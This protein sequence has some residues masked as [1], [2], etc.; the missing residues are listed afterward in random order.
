[1]FSIKVYLF[2]VL[3]TTIILATCTTDQDCGYL[4]DCI[5]NQCQ[6]DNGW[7]GINCSTL[8]FLP[9]LPN[10]GLRQNKSQNWCGTILPSEVDNYTFTMYSSDMNN[11]SL[12]VWLSGS[13]I[14]EAQS[15]TGPNGPYIPTGNIA[16]SAEAHNPSALRAPDGTYILFDSYGGPDSNCPLEA[17]L[18]TCKSGS[19]CKPKMPSNGGLG[20][21]VFHISNSVN[22]PWTPFNTTIDFPCF[23][24]NL[25]PAPVFLT[26]GSLVIIFHC[27]ND[28]THKQGD[29]VMVRSDDWRNQPF[30]RVNNVVWNVCGNGANGATCVQPHPE[31][32]FFFTRTSPTKGTVSYHI[33]LHNTPRGIH[34]FSAD[35][36]TFTLQQDV[37]NGGN[38]LAPFVYENII[39]QTDGTNLTA[40]RR[41]RPWL[42]RNSNGQFTSLVTSMQ[43][44]GI[45]NV[46]THVQALNV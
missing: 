6:C 42:L 23:S 21:W 25:T 35:G 38:P 37:D 17:N 29:L 34:L 3:F 31:D 11:C 30:S 5:Q 44:Q 45:S 20:W 36:N 7:I 39:Q 9:A 43:A 27:D 28:A 2:L 24:E 16:I 46:F 19:M 33:L 4:G 10:S 18:T 14:I 26:N 15:I 41:E 1:M 8:S 22:G 12:D 40:I 13:Q 32:P